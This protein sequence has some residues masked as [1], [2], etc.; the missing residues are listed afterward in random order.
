MILFFI[1]P[2]MD[3]CLVSVFVSPQFA[4]ARTAIMSKML[5]HFSKGEKK[6]L[7]STNCRTKHLHKNAQMTH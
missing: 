4:V 1:K 3:F 7:L 5:V 6:N 2:K